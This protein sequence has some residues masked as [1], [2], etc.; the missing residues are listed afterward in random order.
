MITT[1]HIER[2]HRT[3]IGH[4]A[5][6]EISI[7]LDRYF[8]LGESGQ[9]RC[10][11]LIGESG[12][13]KSHLVNRYLKR[14]T[15]ELAATDQPMAGVDVYPLPFLRVETPPSATLKGL[16]EALLTHLGDPTPSRGSG[17]AMTRR[18][19]NLIHLR[20]TKAVILDEFQH[21]IDRRNGNE[22][23]A[24]VTADW[25]KGLMNQTKCLFLLV[26]TEAA[27]DVIES[28]EQLRRRCSAI[29]RLPPFSYGS[30]AERD[31]FQSLLAAFEVQLNL[32]KSSDLGSEDMAGRIH[33]ATYGLMGHITRLLETGLFAAMDCG[34]P[35]LSKEVLSNAFAQTMTKHDRRVNPFRTKEVPSLNSVPKQEK[36]RLT[37][38]RG[39]GTRKQSASE[40][41][42]V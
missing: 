29:W 4:S 11:L 32:P 41:L 33:Y 37:R 8:Q 12:S 16:V 21:L 5:L 1:E 42:R 40:L 3:S 15:R 9:A 36:S 38:L 14:K 34:A 10:M 28:N 7:A 25:V 30:A 27:E 24:H 6:K 23:V 20:K 26:G 17:Q 35:S 13:G 39:S 2:L 18:A 19:I 31:A 22:R